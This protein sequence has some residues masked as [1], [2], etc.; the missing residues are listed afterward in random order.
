MGGQQRRNAPRSIQS[1]NTNA[2]SLTV[3]KGRSDDECSDCTH[4]TARRRV[5][6]AQRS[7]Q[8]TTY[9]NDVTGDVDD[10]RMQVGDA[11]AAARTKQVLAAGN[12]KPR[13]NERGTSAAESAHRY[14]LS[15]H[16]ADF[17]PRY[18]EG[19]TCVG[20]TAGAE[21]RDE[22]G[23]PPPA[24]ER[25]HTRKHAVHNLWRLAHHAELHRRRWP[26]STESDSRAH[27][28]THKRTRMMD[29]RSSKATLPTHIHNEPHAAAPWILQAPGWVRSAP[30]S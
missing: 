18:E 2:A 26:S 30:V 25:R 23:A 28:C 7:D 19:Q 27:T 20:G 29:S 13:L 8:R 9:R 17:R 24:G 15:Q 21:G 12:D 10:G 3:S 22:V 11:D 14:V 5:N 16:F 6:T 1:L 4:H